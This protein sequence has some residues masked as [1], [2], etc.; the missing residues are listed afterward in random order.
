MLNEAGFKPKE[1]FS[2]CGYNEDIRVM[3]DFSSRIYIVESEKNEG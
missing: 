2:G 1:Q 3:G